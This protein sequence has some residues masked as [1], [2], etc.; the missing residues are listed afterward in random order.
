MWRMATRLDNTGVELTQKTTNV[1]F[2]WSLFEWVLLAKLEVKNNST[3]QHW[4]RW[5][6]ANTVKLGYNELSYNEPS[7]ITNKF[8]G[9]IGHFS[10]H[11]TPV[12]TKPGYN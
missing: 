11:M 4:F 2:L 8:L 1:E 9:K 10:T 7:V 6:F 5:N 3:L 12:I